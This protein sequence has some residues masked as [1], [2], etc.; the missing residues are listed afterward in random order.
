MEM[1]EHRTVDKSEWGDGPWQN[2]PDKVQWQDEATGLPCL[3][4]RGPQGA[5]CGYVGVAEGHPAFEKHYDDVPDM[6]VHG[7][8]TFADHCHSGPE[9]SAICHVPAEGEP[10]VAPAFESHFKSIGMSDWTRTYR[11]LDYVKGEV[12]G[13]ALQLHAMEA[14]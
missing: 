6:V 1:R 3:I 9:E 12:R 11:E 5:L 7:G 4:V 2:E 14:R 8:L 10:D 13:L